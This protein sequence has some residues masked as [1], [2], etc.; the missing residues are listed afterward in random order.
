MTKH[1]STISLISQM[2]IVGLYLLSE[3]TAKYKVPSNM[4]VCLC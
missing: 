2:Q 1:G 4:L 3:N